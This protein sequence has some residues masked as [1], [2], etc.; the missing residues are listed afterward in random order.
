[1]VQELMEVSLGKR[2]ADLVV[3]NGRIVNVYSKEIYDG[4]VAVYKD[5]IAAVGDVDY[6]V[7]KDT[8]V[9]DAD[10]K[11]LTPGFIDGHIH[12]ESTNL[13]PASFAEGV[14]KHGTTVIMTDF[15]EIG[16]VSGLEGI[17]AVLDEM[18]QTDLRS[19]FIVP[20]HVPFSPNLET[21]GGTFDP[22]IIRRA[23]KRP[24]AVGLSECVGNYIL[25][26]FPQ[27]LESMKDTKDRN[28]SLQGHLPD[29]KGRELS[30]ALAAGIDTDH[31]SLS[32]EEGV[33]RLRGG[34]FLMAREGSSAHNLSD[35]LK[36][37]LEQKMDTS[38]VSIVTDDLHVIDL[39]DKGHLD[40]SVRV[41]MKEG[42]DFVT[43]IQMVTVNAARAFQ[44]EYSIGGLAP[45]KRADINI[46][47]GPDDFK[48][49]SVVAGG[50]LVVKDGVNV[51][52]YPRV[53][54]D[55]VLLD[56]V[57]LMKPAE[58]SDF[59]IKVDRNA[60]TVVAKV[61]DT[62]PWIP[63]TQGR[64]VTLQVKNGIVQNDIEQD[65][66]YISQVERHGKN[67]NIGNAF[68]GGFHMSKGAIAYSMGHDNHNIVVLG[69]DKE[70]MAKAVN[71]VVE[72]Q[73][74]QVFVVDGEVKS[75]I[76]LPIAGLLTD[77]TA[78]QLADKKREFNNV[79][80]DLGSP[81]PFPDMFLSFIC[82]AAIPCYAVTDHGF[83][84]VLQQAVIDPILKVNM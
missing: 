82:L 30:A 57:N 14:L 13:S 61:M 48:V 55:P 28:L 15:H 26:G 77:L 72:L 46:T 74:G 12:P 29:L 1:M 5:K 9:I 31:E 52:T 41:A 37:V 51:V 84:D 54:H 33:E 24:D 59:D 17:E 45:G 83:I 25:A 80:R 50:R 43:A 39:I 20:S 4:G 65:V 66:L 3:K 64:D 2:P 63:I 36:P 38:H 6:T 22:R 53:E 75:E 78:E 42:F 81:I 19:Y 27:L 56:T 21:S 67:G 60:G 7:G 44:L 68:M 58:A 32:G 35:V 23:L 76:A 62:L 40:E 11:Y 16:V 73:G 34:C 8:V 47:T 18:S 10:G 79:A 71:R 70:D 49:E 69:A